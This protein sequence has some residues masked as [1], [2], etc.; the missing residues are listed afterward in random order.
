MSFLYLQGFKP[1]QTDSFNTLY[2]ILRLANPKFIALQISEKDYEEKY[3]PVMRHPRFPE[4]MDKIDLLLKIK[5]EEIL[6]SSDLDLSFFENF[7]CLDYCQKKKCKI[8]YC[9]RQADENQKIYEVILKN[10]YNLTK[11]TRRK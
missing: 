8:L 1:M 9:G 2:D 3:Q 10:F 4:I 6:K 5:S 11:K 7:Y